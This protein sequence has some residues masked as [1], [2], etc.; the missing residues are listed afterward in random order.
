MPGPPG[1]LG[2]HRPECPTSL[3]WGRGQGPLRQTAKLHLDIL[4]S[5]LGVRREGLPAEGLCTN[6]HLPG[7][8]HGWGRGTASPE[9]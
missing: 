5:T 6:A 7:G 9:S 4:R 3:G 8:R 2:L 1:L